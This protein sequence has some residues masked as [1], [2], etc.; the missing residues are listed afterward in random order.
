MHNKA[1]YNADGDFL[2][3]PQQGPLNITTELG[4]IHVDINE[5]CVIQQGI[6]FS[7]EVSGPSR[8][9]I[10]EVFNGHFQLPNLGPIGSNGLANPRDFL[11]PAA[12]FEDR[13]VEE[14][15]SIVSKFQ[16]V[17]FE[18]TQDHT[19]FDV[20]AWHGN[21]A[22]YK[23][24]LSN[25]VVVNSVSVDHMDPSIFTVLTCPSVKPG[26]AV[27][28]FVIFPPRWS[29][30]EHTFRPPYYHRISRVIFITVLSMLS[31]TQVTV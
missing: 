18:A 17:L 10:L 23:Y 15:Y 4:K 16:G 13:R 27:A 20:V 5:I 2:I 14:G 19:P 3:V 22:P 11:T 1:F 29:V 8:G 30:Q 6:R 25:F 26:V 21:Y 31:L 28:D 7:V 24:N 9:Y 12:S